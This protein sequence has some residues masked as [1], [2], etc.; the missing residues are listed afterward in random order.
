MNVRR[1]L[2]GIALGA[3]V[4]IG[5][6]VAIEGVAHLEAT[7]APL[8]IGL[9]VGFGARKADAS[10]SSGVSY[11]RGALAA[12][13]A[14]G[15]IVCG[16]Y[17]VARV[18]A[19]FSPR[20]ITHAAPHVD[21]GPGENDADNNAENGDGS[22]DAGD[23]QTGSPVG[24]ATVA[25]GVQGGRGA[26]GGPAAPGVNQQPGVEDVN[27]GPLDDAVSLAHRPDQ[28]SVW[29]FVFMAVGTLLAYELARGTEVRYEAPDTDEPDE[30]DDDDE[31]A[32]LGLSANDENAVK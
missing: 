25:T 6:Q 12:A 32:D 30:G 3:L 2:I 26:T 23:A 17:L 7:W 27:R 5:A 14:L 9:L 24:P 31:D 15:A 10:S 11:V 22:D 19:A 13:V 29:Q 20:V 18:R 1:S 8:L 4:G 21:P 16:P 28:F